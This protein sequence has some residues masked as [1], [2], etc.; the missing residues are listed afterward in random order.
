MRT[1]DRLPQANGLA[2]RPLEIA[3]EI[4]ASTGDKSER[5][6]F[7]GCADTLIGLARERGQRFG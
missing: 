6:F 4:G 7:A 5:E 2:M 1:N 3:F